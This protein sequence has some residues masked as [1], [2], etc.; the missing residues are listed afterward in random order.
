MSLV[1]IEDEIV[2]DASAIDV[3][4]A[5][6]DPGAHARWHPFVT[7]IEGEHRQGEIRTCAVIV[8]G[9]QG[10]TKERCVEDDEARRIVWLVE[11]DSTGFGRMVANWRAGFSLSPS[12]R[13][14]VVTA[15]STFEPKNV[16]V[17]AMLPLIR[18]KFHQTQRAILNALRGS[19]EAPSA[20]G[21]AAGTPAPP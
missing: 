1:K 16:L 20:K 7:E 6:K 5:I 10:S 9:K 15:E 2:V 11:E 12:D 17:R 14:T 8:G 13:G 4:N 18:R 19:V 21:R 3:W